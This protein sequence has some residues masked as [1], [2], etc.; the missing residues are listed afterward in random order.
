[1]G[2][3]ARGAGQG[4]VPVAAGTRSGS[5]RPRPTTRRR[6]RAWGKQRRSVPTHASRPRARPSPGRRPA[7]LSGR[8][9]HEREPRSSCVAASTTAAILGLH[10]PF[11]RHFRPR[12]RPPPPRR[13]SAAVGRSLPVLGAEAGRGARSGGRAADDW[14]GRAGPRPGRSRG[15]GAAAAGLGRPAPPGPRRWRATRAARASPRCPGP[16][17]S[18]F[19]TVSG[20]RRAA[21]EPGRGG[22]REGGRARGPAARTGRP[23]TEAG[24]PSPPCRWALASGPSLVVPRSR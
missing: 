13:R 24:A 2:L 3:G 5:R 8:R 18:S 1:M 20:G 4:S 21:A 14:G 6:V 7:H 11:C 23:P 19:R 15:H 17:A 10:P 12:P 9:P 16:A 22:G